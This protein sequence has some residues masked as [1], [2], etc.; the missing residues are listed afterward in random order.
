M[1]GFRA[2]SAFVCILL[3]ASGFFVLLLV[4]TP[5]GTA[6]RPPSGPEETE[7]LHAAAHGLGAGNDLAGFELSGVRISTVDSR[8]AAAR[9]D[10][11]NEEGVVE[12]DGLAIFDHNTGAWHLDFYDFEHGGPGDC[13][14]GA[15]IPIPIPVQLDL[16]LPSCPLGPATLGEDATVPDA[17]GDFLTEPRTLNVETQNGLLR[18]VDIGAWETWRVNRGAKATANGTLLKSGTRKRVRITLQ[19]YR[20]C[21]DEVTFRRLKWAGLRH[22]EGVPGHHLQLACPTSTPSADR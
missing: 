8:W 21:G 7:L 5:T 19:G 13:G 3:A 4:D 11:S 2:S 20:R 12:G 1:R 6:A 18:F 17:A 14:S 9:L 15:S 10:L 22:G 16:R